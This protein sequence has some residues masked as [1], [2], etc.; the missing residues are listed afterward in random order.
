[1]KIY[2]L[3]LKNLTGTLMLVL[4]FGYSLV[5]AQSDS[6]MRDTISMEPNRT[7][8]VFYSLNT[9][10]KYQ[11]ARENWDIQFST[12][13]MDVAIRTNGAQ[14]VKLYIY[15]FSDTTGW[16][17]IDTNGLHLYTSLHNS[18]K[19]W[20][21]GAFNVTSTGSELD[22]G[23]GVYNIFT[24]KI[25]GDS[26]FIIT[27]ASGPAKKLWIIEKNAPQNKYTF[28]FANLD[29]SDETL[30]TFSA[31]DYDSKDFVGYSFANKQFIDR[32]PDSDKW[33][34]LFTKYMTFYNNEMWYP[35]TGVLSNY[36]V[37]IAS[38]QLCDT[39]SVIFSPSM[40]DSANISVIGNN[41]F[42]LVG[43]MP[44]TYEIFDSLVYFVSDQESS[45]WKLIFEYYNSSEGKIGFRKMVVE[46]HS[47]IT[48]IQ[49]TTFGKLAISPNPVQS[50]AHCIFNADQ[51]GEASLSIIDLAGKIVYQR[52]V[53]YENGLNTSTLELSSL[54]QGVYI[55]VL[56]SG[57][58]VLQNKLIKN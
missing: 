13:V 38:Y 2:T 51:K 28:K 40:L 26:L 52:S 9:G 14:G 30:V 17:T 6:F 53:F 42:K 56:R 34:L 23:W 33:D 21:T 15:P 37:E 57:N 20:E 41:W 25:V 29:G 58:Y 5:S 35:V 19:Q 31:N 39:S 32:E 4:L 16:N 43:G 10:G 46:D 8:D 22:Y 49:G 45:I 50:V 12:K 11:Q 54:P 48:E 36:D 7:H 44:P 55:V 27:F 3:I 1:M 47:A 18:D 24:H